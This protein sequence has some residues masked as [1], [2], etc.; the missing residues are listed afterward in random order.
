[1]TMKKALITARKITS[2]ILKITLLLLILLVLTPIG[3]FAWRANQP[4]DMPE[5][6]GRTFYELLAE[7]RQAY[8]DLA[9]AYQ[10]NHPSVEVKKGAC[11]LTEISIELLE[12]PLSGTYAM[13]GIYPEMQK[14]IDPR[15]IQ[16]GYVPAD[17]T[18]TTILPSSWKTF[19]MFVWGTIE[20]APQGPVPYCRIRPPQ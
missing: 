14:S 8:N 7:R 5:Y 6:G 10:T 19:E 11:F 17:A 4:M 3:Y 15:D 18:W 1:M 12:I 2:A 13:A 9:Q 16:N 20:H